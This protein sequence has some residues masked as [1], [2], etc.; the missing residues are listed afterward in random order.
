M[1][2]PTTIALGLG[3]FALMLFGCDGSQPSS[4]PVGKLSAAL[5]FPLVQ[6]DVDA[7]RFDVVA[8]G[9]SC[10]SPALA[11]KTLPLESEPLPASV[12]G[13]GAGMHQFADGLFVLAPGS[14]LVCATPLAAGAPSQGCARA[15]GTAQ[16]VASQTAEVLLVSQCT[17]K[18]NGGLDVV[19]TLNDP[20]LITGLAITPSK[21][22][23]VCESAEIAA[24]ASDPDGDALSYAWM[25]ASGPAGSSLRAA[26]ASAT[27]SGPAGD[28]LVALTVTDVYGASAMLSFPVHIS[29]A[30]CAVA[31]AVQ[32]IFNTNCASCHI[33]N[34]AGGLNL[35]PDVAYGNLVNTHA[36][37]AGCMDRVRVVPG[38]AAGSYLIAKLRNIP[39]IC[40]VQM[41]RN[42]PPLPDATIQMIEAWIAGLPH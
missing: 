37:G 32:A 17:G 21:F 4:G 41:P 5:Q 40:G 28:Y 16:V 33:A 12:A 30:T 8:A 2:T 3:L 42:R 38:D 35:G 1:R 26:G 20:P 31:P 34:S 13:A 9:G 18:P 6:H 15:Q 10:D 11:T 24:T 23:T 36:V 27:F 25:V 39:P 22:I 14:Y 19:A 29:A 7:V